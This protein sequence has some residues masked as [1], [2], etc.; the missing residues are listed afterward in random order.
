MYNALCER[1][2]Y[3]ITCLEF[4]YGD[5]KV[6]GTQ[7]YPTQPVGWPLLIVFYVLILL[8]AYLILHSR[9]KHTLAYI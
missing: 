3:Q 7:P 4:R 8:K 6:L 1:I 2:D 9:I 5:G